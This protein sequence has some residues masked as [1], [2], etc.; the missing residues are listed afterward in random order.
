M[1]KRQPVARLTSEPLLLRRPWKTGDFV[2][3]AQSG[4]PFDSE[5]LSSSDEFER[6]TTL[7]WSPNSIV[8]YTAPVPKLRI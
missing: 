4:K 5:L 8:S 6:E 3:G 2:T 7:N 1:L